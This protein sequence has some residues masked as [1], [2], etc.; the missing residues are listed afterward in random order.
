M[1]YK[2]LFTPI[3]LGPVELKNR[4]FMSPMGVNYSEDPSGNFTERYINYYKERAKNDIGLIIPVHVKCEYKIDPYPVAYKFPCLQCTEDIRFFTELVDEIHLYGS[5]VAVQLCAGAGRNGDSVIDGYY[6]KAPSEVPLLINPNMKSKALTVD[7]IE[8]IIEAY[9]IA[10]G[11][12]KKAGYDFIYIHAMAYLMDQ[13]LTPAWNHRTDKYGGSIENRMRFMMECID[14]VRKYCGANF[15]LIA[16][17][18]MDSGVPG[19]KTL[20]D[21]IAIAQTLEEKGILALHL[22]DGS[23]DNPGK[24]VPTIMHPKITGAE[25][26]AK[27]K[28]Y[29]KIPI[30]VDGGLHDPETCDQI[31]VENKADMTGLGRS[32]LADHE[33]AYKA[34]RG[35]SEEIRPCLRCMECVSHVFKGQYIGC[36]V[37]PLVGREKD[38]YEYSKT[39]SKKVLVIGGGQSG[40]LTALYSAQRGHNVTLVEK[41]SKLGGHLLEGSVASFKK[42]TADYFIWI[43]EQMKKAGVTVLT[44]ITVDK[45]FIKMF[46]PDAVVV[47]TGSVPNIPNVPGI[48]S[49]NVKLATNVLLDDSEV[50]DN[51]VIV[52][53][54]LVGCETAID[55][56][57]KGKKVELIDMTPE[58]GM[59][60]NIITRPYML[61]KINNL[62]IKCKANLK[63]TE[64]TKDG[65]KTI[66]ENGNIHSINAGTVIIAAGL[67][68]VND[69]YRDLY[70]EIENIY[71]VGDSIRPRKFINASREAYAIAELL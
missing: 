34:K 57:M 62:G 2:K 64:V 35:K 36:S 51:V 30:M 55:L 41:G 54:G 46:A 4:I 56:A 38:A 68:S 31:L 27:I 12:A 58:I 63:L 5:K 43:K 6:P 18:S 71:V 60:I 21:C 19:S 59:E 23:Y 33:W 61:E 1:E 29:V 37:N 53:S 25:N 44:G 14:S 32:L 47:C 26:A 15:P 8:E 13:F 39:T 52:G 3:K 40:M 49:K 66:D 48:D 42:D 20:E 16:G 9:G 50:A 17:F 10:A 7:E 65:I 70:S 24:M 67:H 22:R 69:L 11:N 45:D 28:E